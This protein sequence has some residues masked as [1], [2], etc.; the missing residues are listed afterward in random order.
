M[1]GISE[2]AGD[3]N[4]V[5]LQGAV[6]AGS[7][8]IEIG[9]FHKDDNNEKGGDEKRPRGRPPGKKKIK[10][11]SEQ[12]ERADKKLEEYWKKE[13]PNADKEEAEASLT[14]E[15]ELES[16]EKLDEE[17][18]AFLSKSN[19]TR[20]PVKSKT[21][22]KETVDLTVVEDREENIDSPEANQDKKVESSDSEE[23][24]ENS[25]LEE[26]ER[27]KWE[28]KF[29]EKWDRRMAALETL[30]RSE[31]KK[32]HSKK[33]S[34][35]TC[36][37]L[38]E[39]LTK[40]QRKY[41]DSQEAFLEDINIHK[42]K[43]ARLEGELMTQRT[44]FEKIM[45][46][47]ENES[48]KSYA[49]KQTEKAEKS[50]NSEN[51]EGGRMSSQ[52]NFGVQVTDKEDTNKLENLHRSANEELGKDKETGNIPP[53]KL[54]QEEWS[55]EKEE[56]RA[57]KKNIYVS[58]LTLLKR[59]KKE[60]FEDWVFH[61][62]QIK[63]RVEKSERIGNDWKFKIEEW[64]KKLEL[65]KLKMSLQR[66]G[67]GVWISDDLTDRQK[68]VQQWIEREADAWRQRGK[69]VATGYQRIR[70]DDTCL[71]WD[72]LEGELR[73]KKDRDERELSL[74]RKEG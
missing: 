63:I 7:V 53:R 44:S 33:E 42:R 11:N 73:L 69:I 40:I 49:R 61:T 26:T 28:L 34:C 5:E 22:R 52:N 32:V 9:K 25:W 8:Q 58:G 14:N 70:I 6:V 59:E 50:L 30:V 71:M 10:Y 15:N 38:K 31:V 20:T 55:A 54:S 41:E 36:S 3:N 2:K 62:M 67:W 65:M 74:F 56:R 17:A 16:Q 60:E 68:E 35:E 47:I 4:S 29:E 39:E 48:D 57:R 43:I 1:S 37:T 66:L 23:D 72:E 18:E 13:M 12:K 45:R 24:G 64:T 21:K 51:Q 19:L 46:G 27:R